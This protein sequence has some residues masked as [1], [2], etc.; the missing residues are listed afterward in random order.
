MNP[1]LISCLLH[2]L[3]ITFFSILG[4]CYVLERSVFPAYQWGFTRGS[5]CV[6]C[7]I[8]AEWSSLKW[9]L[10]L[11]EFGRRQ[12]IPIW[13]LCSADLGFSFW[14]QRVWP[15]CRD[16]KDICFGIAKGKA[17]RVP[18]W[19]VTTPQPSACIPPSGVRGMG[20]P[21]KPAEVY[22]CISC[23]AIYVRAVTFGK[24]VQLTAGVIPTSAG[25]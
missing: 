18:C 7:F 19:D 3:F 11:G 1:V 22:V 12:W 13:K 16:S 5:P 9:S 14:W 10:S 15:R 25:L 6:S 8:F 4:P 17:A 23:S 24:G 2:G 20:Q 21:L